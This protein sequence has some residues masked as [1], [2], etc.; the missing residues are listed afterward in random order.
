MDGWWHDASEGSVVDLSLHRLLGAQS[1]TET[2]ISSGG[3]VHRTVAGVVTAALL[4]CLTGGCAAIRLADFETL[5]PIPENSC[6]IVG[7]L[8][9]RDAWNDE[10]KGVRQMALRLRSTDHNRFVETFENRSRDVAVAFVVQALDRDKNGKIESNES[11]DVTT[12]IYGQS[13]GGAAA[14]KFARQLD[15]LQIPIHLTVQVD[16]VGRSDQTLPANVKYAANLYQDNGW[17]ISGEHPIAAA[18]PS[19]TT[20]LGNWKFD[21]DHPPGV[22]ISLKALPWYKTAFRRAHAKMDRDP[23]VWALAEELLRSA[24]S[25]ADL[26]QRVPTTDP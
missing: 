16:S 2:I 3:P 14:V 1:R 10:S 18:N 23:R 13:F 17:F 12:V 19:Q 8:G 9:G 5:R 4:L 25:G 7:F 26:E 24:C 6:L 21:Y 15:A 11:S 22:D 20:I